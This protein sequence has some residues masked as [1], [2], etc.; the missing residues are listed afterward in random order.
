VARAGFFDD[1]R[2]RAYPFIVGTTARPIVGAATLINLP[3]SA[4]VDCGFVFGP[5]VDFDPTSH[6][7]YL[8]R[9]RRTGAIFYFEFA[10]TCP[11]LADVTVTFTR[12]VTDVEYLT[13]FADSGTAGVSLSYSGSGSLANDC[14]QPLWSGFLVTGPLTDAAAF[15]NTTG[16]ITGTVSTCVVEPALLLSLYKS[17]VTSVNLANDDRTR[18][19]NPEDCDPMIWPYPVALTFVNSRCIRGDVLFQPGYNADVR[20]S[21]YD[22]SITFAANVGAGEGQPCAEIPLF[23]QEAPPTGSGLLSGGS[24]CGETI[25]TINGVSNGNFILQAGN[26]VQIESIPEENKVVIDINLAGAAA[27]IPESLIPA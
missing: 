12:N 22:N 6:A 20:Q 24:A 21:Y 13:E 3:N 7:V 11:D 23:N 26:G 4:I 5:S 9:L 8:L 2:N 10:S 19:E 17:S 16:A 18:Y 14:V 27:I 1:N 25:Q 15:L